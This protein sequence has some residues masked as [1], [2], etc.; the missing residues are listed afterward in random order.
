MAIPS[1]WVINVYHPFLHEIAI[2][3]VYNHYNV[4]NTGCHK[5]SPSH[6]HFVVGGMVI[7]PRK[8]GGL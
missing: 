7:I 8:M 6:H 1:P 2:L 4:D 5:L 3:W